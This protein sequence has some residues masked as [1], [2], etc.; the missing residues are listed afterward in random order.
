MQVVRSWLP[1]WEGAGG[2]PGGR[3]VEHVEGERGEEGEGALTRGEPHVLHGDAWCD[4]HPFGGP[5]QRR[6]GAGARSPF[7]QLGGSLGRPRV[8][9]GL[10]DWD[11][12]DG[13]SRLEMEPLGADCVTGSQ[14]VRRGPVGQVA[15]KAAAFPLCRLQHLCTAARPQLSAAAARGSVAGMERVALAL[16]D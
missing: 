8:G 13:C 12:Q 4:E 2:S 15:G 14:H 16:W 9:R 3:S 10:A 6:E 7:A 1:A 11:A 5:I